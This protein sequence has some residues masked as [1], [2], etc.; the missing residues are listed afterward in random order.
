MF[1]K[2]SSIA[3]SFDHAVWEIV[4]YDLYVVCSLYILLMFT[5][6]K[7]FV[8]YLLWD[9][10]LRST[11]FFT[12]CF[13]NIHWKCIIYSFGLQRMIIEFTNWM[14]SNTGNF[15]CDY[16][17]WY[18]KGNLSNQTNFNMNDYS[19]DAKEQDGKNYWSKFQH[20][21]NQWFKKSN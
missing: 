21:S 16:Y 5:K 2:L 14:H 3:F 12:Y 7:T 13:N 1:I 11:N 10:S 15:L 6:N 4:H 17:K 19:L 18:T 9:C 20:S 8:Y